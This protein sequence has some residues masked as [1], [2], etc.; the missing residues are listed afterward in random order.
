MGLKKEVQ[1]LTVIS[2]IKQLQNE[3]SSAD[4][5]VYYFQIMKMH[6]KKVILSKLRH[7]V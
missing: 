7:V 4:E 6:S 1:I 5:L 2:Y 3:K